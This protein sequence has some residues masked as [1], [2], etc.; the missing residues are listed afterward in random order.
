LHNFIP[1]Y[2]FAVLGTTSST[3]T[4]M[5]NLS[6]LSLLLILLEILDFVQSVPGAT[7][8]IKIHVYPPSKDRIDLVCG[9]EGYKPYYYKTFYT[10]GSLEWTFNTTEA[11]E[12]WYCQAHMHRGCLKKWH[13]MQTPGGSPSLPWCEPFVVY[14]SWF[15][16]STVGESVPAQNNVWV[17][18]KL[19]KRLVK[20]D[21]EDTVE[22]PALWDYNMHRTRLGTVTTNPPKTQLPLYRSVDTDY[23]NSILKLDDFIS[24]KTFQSL[25]SSNSLPKWPYPDA[26]YSQIIYDR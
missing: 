12:G 4:K 24:N 18:D 21:N 17:I 3:N 1:K 15:F 14:G 23:F 25:D 9:S 22:Y 11:D 20:V 2:T 8:G 13:Q 10:S 16:N 6:I 7:Y 5:S 19:G 26:D